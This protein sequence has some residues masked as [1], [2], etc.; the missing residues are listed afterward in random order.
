M[1][2]KKE[3]FTN[4]E[5]TLIFTI[6]ILVI[7]LVLT[8]SLVFLLKRTNKANDSMIYL[9]ETAKIEKNSGSISIPGYESLTFM[10]DTLDQ[11][12]QLK[13]P[14]QNNCYFIISLLLDDGTMLWKS[15]LVAPGDLS[16]PIVFSQALEKGTYPNSVIS[17]SCFSMDDMSPLNS[18]NT[19]LTLRVK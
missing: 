3:K 19:K 18:A 6:I 10:A 4:F 1:N 7:L 14:S 15:D 12:I 5:R 2:T 17:Y 11:N 13:N 9:P 16:D 8:A